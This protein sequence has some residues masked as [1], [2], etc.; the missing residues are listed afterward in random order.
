MNITVADIVQAL[1]AGNDITVIINGEYYTIT[2]GAEN[3]S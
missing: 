3:E 2:G 1:Q